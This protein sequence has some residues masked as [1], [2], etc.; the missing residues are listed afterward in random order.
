[1]DLVLT[2]PPYG[3]NYEDQ[4]KRTVANDDGPYIWWMRDAFERA[5]QGACCICFCRW[6]VQEPFRHALT[7]AGWRVRSQVVW[8]KTYGGQG[9]CKAQF[10]PAHE[11][12][13]FATKGRGFAFP[14]A[15][16]SSVQTF[17]KLNWRRMTHPTEKPVA[18]MAALVTSLTS[19]GDVVVDPF[20]GSGSVGAACAQTGRRFIG[21]EIDE[22]YVKQARHRIAGA[23]RTAPTGSS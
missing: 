10:S 11:I 14:D 6:D 9:D 17:Q 18:L 16:P 19:A 4:Q 13:W 20:A 2:D 22:K 8:D 1:M 15:R 3:I 7:W 12:A 23:L 21:S 5:R